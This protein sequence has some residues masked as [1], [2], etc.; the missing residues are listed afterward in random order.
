MA[1]YAGAA[2]AGSGHDVV[3][4]EVEDRWRALC[5]Q[6][7]HLHDGPVLALHRYDHARGVGAVRVE[8]YRRLCVQP[9][10][11]TGV[12]QLSVTGLLCARVAGARGPADRAVLLARRSDETRM[13]G[14]CW[15][16]APS[17]GIDAPQARSN[18]RWVEFDGVHVYAQLMLEAHEELGL[19]LDGSSAAID[20]ARCL[21][22]VHDPAASS[23]DLVIAV[24][25]DVEVPRDAANASGSGVF[26]GVSSWEYTARRWVA[27]PELA[28]F[29]DDV[30]RAGELVPTVRPSLRLAGLLG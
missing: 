30:E 10:V 19:T 29:L 12:V 11:P 17:G 16:L 25:V 23:A 26:A 20:A 22:I 3:D 28:A 5:A 2:G 1:G 9:E 18:A 7:P 13:Y 14:S 8:T 21:G 24:D 27:Q 6:N 4:A 15:E